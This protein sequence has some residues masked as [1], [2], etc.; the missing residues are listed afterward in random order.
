[1]AMRLS[2]ALRLLSGKELAQRSPLDQLGPPVAD[3]RQS[4]L[5]GPESNCVLVCAKQ[6]GGFFDRV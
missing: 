5:C 6:A 3:D 4:A 1:M 2:A